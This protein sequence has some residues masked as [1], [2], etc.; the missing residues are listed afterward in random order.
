MKKVRI[1]E[2]TELEKEF[3]LDE[4]G[5]INTTPSFTTRMYE[6]L[7]KDNIINLVED[8]YWE[9]RGYIIT[10]DMIAEY[11]EEPAE[12]S[13]KIPEPEVDDTFSINLQRLDSI[14]KKSN[15]IHYIKFK[16]T[17]NLSIRYFYNFET[18]PE[19]INKFALKNHKHKEVREISE[20]TAK[21]MI[22]SFVT[23]KFEEII[24]YQLKKVGY[25]K[26]IKK[27]GEDFQEFFNV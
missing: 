21:E 14:S 11:I 27:F 20:E 10:E 4:D 7:P 24:G 6:F 13:E 17:D 23:E 16:L 26:Y 15:H 3:G 9:D 22:K 25:K 19:L 18:R 8:W 2:W 1:K 5:D 12:I